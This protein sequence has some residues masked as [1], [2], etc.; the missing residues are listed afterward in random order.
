MIIN[1][2]IK[3]GCLLF[4]FGY[5]FDS[6]LDKTLGSI[7]QSVMTK[8][9]VFVTGNLIFTTIVEHDIKILSVS[10]N[11]NNSIEKW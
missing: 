11:E 3:L 7:H 6:D 8:I 2:C 1:Q 9:K 10:I 4:R 5:G